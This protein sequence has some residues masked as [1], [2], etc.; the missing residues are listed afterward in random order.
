MPAAIF[1]SCLPQAS[2]N[3]STYQPKFIPPNKF[4]SW[5]SGPAASS[6]AATAK[7]DSPTHETPA[8]PGNSLAQE[9]LQAQEQERACLA[10]ELHDKLGQSLILLKNQV[11]KIKTHPPEK[12]DTWAQLNTLAEI[13][14]DSLQQVRTMSYALRP[15]ELNLLGLTQAVR[16]LV[17]AIAPTVSWPLVVDLPPLDQLFPKEREIYI[18]RIMQECWQLIQ[19]QTE[20]A[21]VR[22]QAYTRPTTVIWEIHVSGPA[23]FFSFLA[24]EFLKNFALCRLQ[25]YLNL[26]EGR[27][28]F[29]ATTPRTTIMQ[30]NV[31]L[32]SDNPNHEKT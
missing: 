29:I 31:P 25:E 21:R 11:L 7:V 2:S 1:F 10:Q 17:D 22:L 15:F 8:I 28:T 23:T 3:W 13:V 24:T 26:V 16:G 18:Y 12:S 30:I 32:S 4:L 14:T 20:V 5:Q 19:S 27:L 6:Q 9:L